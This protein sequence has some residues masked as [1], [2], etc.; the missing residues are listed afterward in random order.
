MKHKQHLDSLVSQNL[1][2]VLTP[3]HR[4]RVARALQLFTLKQ[5]LYQDLYHTRLDLETFLRSS[6]LPLALQEYIRHQQTKAQ[7]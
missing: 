4:E 6:N 2:L 7:E 1:E 5:D 3:Y